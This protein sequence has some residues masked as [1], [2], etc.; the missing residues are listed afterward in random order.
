ME[1]TSKP[2]KY[3]V[4]IITKPYLLNTAGEE[5]ETL[6]QKDQVIPLL[7]AQQVLIKL[8]KT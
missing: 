1:K 4:A 6:S 8:Y 5:I 2:K 3:P 7:I